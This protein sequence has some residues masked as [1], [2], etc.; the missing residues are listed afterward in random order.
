MAALIRIVNAF[1]AALFLVAFLASLGFLV[2]ARDGLGRGAALW[3]SSGWAALAALL[4][5]LCVVNM[6]PGRRAYRL[7][8][9]AANLAAL[10]LAGAGLLAANPVLQWVG[11]VAILPFAIT[12]PALIARGDRA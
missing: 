5:I 11:G 2:A 7:P 3:L 6:R 12:L 1:F 9:I 8:L 10:L 4:A